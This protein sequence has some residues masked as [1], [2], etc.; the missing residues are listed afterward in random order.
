MSEETIRSSSRL[1]ASASWLDSALC[2]I[3]A[4]RRRLIVSRVLSQPY[5]GSGR[6]E[7]PSLC[8]TDVES[9]GIENSQS[10]SLSQQRR[11]KSDYS[12]ETRISSATIS[13]E[14]PTCRDLSSVHGFFRRRTSAARGGCSFRLGWA[15]LRKLL[16]KASTPRSN[17][18]F[19]PDSPNAPECSRVAYPCRK[20]Q[21]QGC[22]PAARRRR[23]RPP[24]E[25]SRR[26]CPLLTHTSQDGGSA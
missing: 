12:C 17:P 11:A 18:P 4:P 20:A 19:G 15:R 23:L 10:R 2:S 22:R 25:G 3:P 26:L 16:K 1:M 13:A 7:A 21:Q 14:K 8:T 24:G 5:W 9:A 6:L